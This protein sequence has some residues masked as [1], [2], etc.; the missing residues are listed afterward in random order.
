MRLTYRGAS[1]AREPLSLEVTEKEIGGLY[2]GQPWKHRYPRHIPHLRHQPKILQYRGVV[3]QTQTT[4]LPG[5]RI[6]CH[7]ET[8]HRPGVGEI[9]LEPVSPEL[10]ARSQ[11]VHLENLRRNLAH[12]LQVAQAK[13][14]EILVR[15]LEEES[16]QLA[17]NGKD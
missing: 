1:Y 4:I 17:L 16:R 3:Y 9:Q 8:L 6:A 2:R 10:L 13:G 12:R 15:Q 14:N 7:L 11:Q 5:P